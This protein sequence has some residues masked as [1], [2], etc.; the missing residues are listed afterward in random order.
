MCIIYMLM[1]SR[2][3]PK[4]NPKLVPEGTRRTQKHQREGGAGWRGGKRQTDRERSNVLSPLL[5]QRQEDTYMYVYICPHLCFSSGL[6]LCGLFRLL[7]FCLCFSLGLCQIHTN[8][9]IHIIY[10]YVFVIFFTFLKKFSIFRW[11]GFNNFIIISFSIYLRFF[12]TKSTYFA[13]SSIVIRL[14]SCF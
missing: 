5:Q 3:N 7:L 4:R 14:T 8:T 1:L 11:V 2:A 12:R 9:N 13:S 6:L 10:I